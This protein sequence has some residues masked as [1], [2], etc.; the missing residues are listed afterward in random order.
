MLDYNK[1]FQLSKREQKIV[2]MG[3]LKFI[4]RMRSRLDESESHEEVG[5]AGNKLDNL[6][7]FV[8]L[9]TKRTSVKVSKGSVRWDKT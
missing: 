5:I 4:M 9:C 3:R 6:N 7:P 8:L 2:Q 1:D